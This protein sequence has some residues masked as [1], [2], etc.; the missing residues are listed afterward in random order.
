MTDARA[1]ETRGFKPHVVIALLG[2]SG[3]TLRYWRKQLDPQPQRSLFSSPDVLALRLI[4]AFT[5]HHDTSVRMLKKCG[6]SSLFDEFEKTPMYILRDRIA[7]L[8]ER[9]ET[10]SLIPHDPGFDIDDFRLHGIGLCT[11]VNEHLESL[12][13]F[14]SPQSSVIDFE[15]HKLRS[16]QS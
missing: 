11:V 4:K 10:I 14:G 6:F 7:L 5:H 9:N 3:Q 1:T 16:T 13:R 15:S 2:I 8:D 12:C